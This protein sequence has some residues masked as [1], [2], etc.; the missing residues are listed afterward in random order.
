MIEIDGGQHNE[1]KQINYDWTRT[2]KLIDD[3]FQVLRFWNNEVFT[4][5]DDVLEGINRAK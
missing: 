5:I 3:H 4:S 2:F 1:E